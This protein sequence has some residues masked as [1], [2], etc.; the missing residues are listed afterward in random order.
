MNLATHDGN[1]IFSKKTLKIPDLV[2]ENNIG[3]I[4][5]FFYNYKIAQLSDSVIYN[6]AEQEYWVEDKPYYGYAIIFVEFWYDNNNSRNFYR[7]IVDNKCKIAY[8]DTDFWEVEFY[9]Y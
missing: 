8:D 5:D 2:N 9:N 4:Y 1:S 6:H 3:R 7:N